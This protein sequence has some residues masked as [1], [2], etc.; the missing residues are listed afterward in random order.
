MRKREVLDSPVFFYRGW[1]WG[2][3]II[4]KCLQSNKHILM[5][6]PD[7]TPNKIL[8]QAICPPDLN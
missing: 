8:L 4:F 3:E 2:F 7:L 5:D 1:A 6:N